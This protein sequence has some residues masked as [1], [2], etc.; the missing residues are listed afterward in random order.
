MSDDAVENAGE[1]QEWDWERLE[2]LLQ[3]LKADGYDVTD[4][5]T[6]TASGEVDEKLYQVVVSRD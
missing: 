2:H 6:Q 4:V 1:Q 3:D 5:I